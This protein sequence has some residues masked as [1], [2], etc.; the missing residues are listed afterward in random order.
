MTGLTMDLDPNLAYHLILLK[1]DDSD[2]HDDDIMLAPVFTGSSQSIQPDS[3]P[4][5]PIGKTEKG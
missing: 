5:W 1:I 3:I 4:V 2:D